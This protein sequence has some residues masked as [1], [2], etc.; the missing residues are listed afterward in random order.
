MANGPDPSPDPNPFAPPRQWTAPPPPPFVPSDRPRSGPP[1]E[2]EGP[3]LARFWETTRGVL[4]EPT[5]FFDRMRREGGLG[6][7][8][9][10]HMIG[11][12]AS[13][14]LQVL[15]QLPIQMLASQGGDEMVFVAI[16]SLTCGVI[17]APVMS[18][19]YLFLWAGIQHLML[20]M[21]K[22]ANFPFEATLRVF[23]YSY[24]ATALVGV[25][26]FCGGMI[27]WVWGIVANIIGL[28]RALEV[29]TGK[30]AG[31]GLAPVFFFC[32]IDLE[33]VVFG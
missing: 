19:V 11:F 21:L 22:S 12:T 13:T 27:G 5:T 2:E 23:A 20:L 3:F 9:V 33:S 18:I 15:Y 6:K 1:W 4:F 8:I 32:G 7:P 24:G 30:A 14:I 16:F 28:S 29:P 26:P 17:L 31:V 25:I 10:Y